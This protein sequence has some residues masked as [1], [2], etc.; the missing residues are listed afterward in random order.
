M[1]CVHEFGIIGVLGSIGYYNE[2]NPQR[3]NCVAV[4]DDIINN[5]AGN[6]SNMRTFFHSFDRPEHGL[7]YYGITLI[8]P[9]SLSLFYNAVTSSLCY[10]NSAELGE[11]ASKINQAME[12]QKHMIHY[13]V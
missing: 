4:H 3:Y 11:L 5:I 9:E 13:G 10:K 1:P 8:P 12:E 7:A 2:Y 6:L